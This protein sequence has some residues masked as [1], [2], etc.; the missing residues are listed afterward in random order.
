MNKFK[1]KHNKNKKGLSEIIAYTLLILI[2]VAIAGAIYAW[3]QIQLPKER[4]ECPE[5]VSVSIS[6][7]SC[8]DSEGIINITFK[9]KGLFNL[10]GANVLI[11]SDSNV[12]S[13]PIIALSEIGQSIQEEGFVYFNPSLLSGG[14]YYEVFDYSEFGTI[15]EI[16]VLPF[17]F[18]KSIG[19]DD[20]KLVLCKDAII[21]QKITC[22]A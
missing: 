22:N 7:Y 1:M 2:A 13:K 11:S 18:R 6:S 20:I 8:D 21:K 9:N 14:E 10:D 5:G 3:L 15:T 16:Q 12:P 19:N 17:V 4:L